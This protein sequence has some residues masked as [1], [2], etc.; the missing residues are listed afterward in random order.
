V[1]HFSDHSIDRYVEYILA[2][3]QQESEAA[4]SAS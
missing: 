1:D 2:A 4:D 3:H